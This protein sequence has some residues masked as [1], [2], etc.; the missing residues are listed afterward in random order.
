MGEI[1]VVSSGERPDLADQACAAFRGEW[2]EFIFHDLVSPAHTGRA[3]KHV[4]R[5]DILPPD[6]DNIIAGPWGD[7]VAPLQRSH[8]A[9]IARPIYALYTLPAVVRYIQMIMTIDRWGVTYIALLRT[10]HRSQG[11]DQ[12][13]TKYQHRS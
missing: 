13:L 11:N 5:Y 9:R 12:S 4:P 7:D 6:E 1:E 10:P 8:P 3:E 2:P